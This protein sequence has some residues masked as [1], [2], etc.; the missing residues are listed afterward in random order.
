VSRRNWKYFLN[1][2]CLWPDKA[3]TCPWRGMEENNMVPSLN[4]QQPATLFCSILNGV[5]HNHEHHSL[6]TTSHSR[7]C[8]MH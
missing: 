4:P 5:T 7:R 3:F 8:F 6:S 1:K 2:G